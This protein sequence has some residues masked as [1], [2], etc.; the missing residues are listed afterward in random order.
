[1]TLHVKRDRGDWPVTKFGILFLIPQLQQ[2]TLDHIVMNYGD[3]ESPPW[4]SGLD[5]YSNQTGL[6]SLSIT[7][8]H[9]DLQ[10]LEE[11]LSF[12]RALTHLRLESC[13]PDC[14][15]LPD[16]WQE[17]PCNR[18]A[19]YRAIAQQ[20]LSLEKLNIRWDVRSEPLERPGWTRVR[21]PRLR[22]RMVTFG[23]LDESHQIEMNSGNEDVQHPDMNP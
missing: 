12:P 8:S 21:F 16:E 18:E 22:E 20:R 2:L 4:P 9:V 17:E 5:H 6:K 11:I 15:E 19:I 7:D 14:D 23:A 10:A 1:M 13:Y 3:P